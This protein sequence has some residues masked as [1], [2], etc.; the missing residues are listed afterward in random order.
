MENTSSEINSSETKGY[1]KSCNEVDIS[2][3][4]QVKLADD[5]VVVLG[6]A[7]NTDIVIQAPDDVASKG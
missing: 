5:S 4:E 2:Y 3:D 1:S 6:K 7:S